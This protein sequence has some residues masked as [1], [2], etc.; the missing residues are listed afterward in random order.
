MGVTVNNGSGSKVDYYAARSVDYDVQLGG[1]G[2]AIGT[3]NVTIAND[4]P[5]HARDLGHVREAAGSV[6]QPRLVDDQLERR[7][8]LLTDR[9]CRQVEARHQDHRLDASEGVA[10]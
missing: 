2:E 10:W 8:D 6:L 4:A 1:D 9:S 7:R 3:A 5:T